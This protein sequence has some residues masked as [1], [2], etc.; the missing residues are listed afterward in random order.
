MSGT[1][2]HAGLAALLGCVAVLACTPSERAT[3]LAIGATLA[4]RGPALL[5]LTTTA[6]VRVEVETASA[7]LSLVLWDAARTS[8]VVV[9]RT[10]STRG[11]EYV[12]TAGEPGLLE[13]RARG[14][15]TV[16]VTRSTE[17]AVAAARAEARGA[18]AWRAQT[19]ARLPE[20]RAAY[21]EAIAL[22]R[23]T[24]E[25]RAVVEALLAEARVARRS[26]DN[27]GARRSLDAAEA[28]LRGL[29][30]DE[31]EARVLLAAGN[32]AH[33]TDDPARAEQYAERA[34]ALALARDDAL[35]L[36]WAD[37]RAAEIRLERDDAAQALIALTAARQRALE[38]GDDEL[39][40]IT[41]AVIGW[42]QA[43]LGDRARTQAAFEESLAAAIRS[44]DRG[45]LAAALQTMGGLRSD[46]DGDWRG[47]LPWYLRAI[48]AAQAAGDRGAEAYSLDAAGEMESTLGD[49]GALARHR[50]ALQIRRDLGTARGEAQSLLSLGS[51]YTRLGQPE[52]AFAPL[53]Q[54]AEMLGRLGDRSWEAYAYFRIGR[55]EE[56]RQRWPE[57]LAWAERALA[58]TSS[59]RERIASD[60]GRAY[61]SASIRMYDELAV[62][63]AVG[64]G[65]PDHALV[66]SERARARALV[67]MLALFDAGDREDPE[68]TALR[69]KVRELELELRRRR[70]RAEPE[71]ELMSLE[72]ELVRALGAYEARRAHIDPRSAALDASSLT[73]LPKVQRLLEPDTV[74]LEVFLGRRASWLF[75]VS[76]S[77]VAAH[78]LPTDATVEDDARALH[79]AL[80]ARNQRL[81]GETAALRAERVRAAD[82]DAERLAARLSKVLLAPLSRALADKK[83]LLFIADGA[84]HYVPLAMLPL[85]TGGGR[86]ID[87]WEVSSV[88]SLT[89]LEALRARPRRAVTRGVAALADPVF[90]ADDPRLRGELEPVS[91]ST[92][93]V[94]AS[95]DLT[96]DGSMHLARLVHTRAEAQAIVAQVPAGER[97][98]WLDTEATRARALS[99]ELGRRRIVHLAT[100]GVIDAQHPEKSGLVFS[101]VDARGQPVEAIL[102]LADVY[103]LRWSSELVTLSGCETALGEE[104]RGEGLMGLTRG[105]LHAGA[106]RVLASLWKVNDRATAEL[107]TRT[108]RATLGEG[109]A[110]AAAL[111]AAQRGLAA[112][113]RYAA[114]YY[115]AAFQVHGEP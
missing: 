99:D 38:G 63:A 108:Y 40:S 68:S 30:D 22:W 53:E 2:L 26:G 42:A 16:R 85:P 33:S 62:T 112:D 82:A 25:A 11:T 24:G 50:A 13:V 32:L 43:R 10:R 95:L 64:T 37:T 98:L 17:A 80:S 110:P 20:A 78:R 59:L 1:R 57:A 104:V 93:T 51:A 92:P 18:A 46:F 60:D 28:V 90:D 107:M 14:P 72:A 77:S 9:D 76:S 91:T 65:R 49:P 36:A 114:P 69:R 61:Y 6:P 106:R 19:A 44:R 113:P 58:M 5:T 55:A 84:L 45:L 103:G 4:L 47:A 102:S 75:T 79:R 31:L 21:A 111:A 3:P 70:A 27:A 81:P 71:R 7:G 15:A 29:R 8:S 23:T 39:L 101:R 105:F 67:D 74:A 52:L 88:P 83:R 66:M 115:W 48:E 54:S 34:R 94:I 56:A 86:V 12:H 89:V 97:A 109:R 73:S 41:T 96:R 35:L 87:R 100:H